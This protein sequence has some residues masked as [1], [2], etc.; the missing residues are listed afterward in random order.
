MVQIEGLSRSFGARPRS[1]EVS[2]SVP[3]GA[4]FGLVGENA[5]GKTTLIKHILGLLKAQA[6]TVRV[7]GLDPVTEPVGVLSRLGYLSEDRDLP[8]WMR[9]HEMLRYLQAFYPSWDDAYAEELRQKFDLDPRA[10]SRRCRKARGRGR[11]CWLRWRSGRSSSCS[12]SRRR[13][14]TRSCAGRFCRRSS[15]RSLRRVERSSS[16]HICWMR[17]SAFPIT[18]R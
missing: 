13:G 5:A 10:A 9:L 16:R 7:F 2:L 18:S 14:L 4:V 3:R 11:G 12:M 17:S 6:G 1:S 15:A 8:D